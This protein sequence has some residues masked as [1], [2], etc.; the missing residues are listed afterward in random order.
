VS[1]EGIA[2]I[3]AA[4]LCWLCG[5][6]EAPK[7]GQGTHLTHTSSSGGGDLIQSSKDDFFHIGCGGV[8]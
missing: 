3:N 2:G 4:A 7:R 5:T 6:M 8:I 1:L